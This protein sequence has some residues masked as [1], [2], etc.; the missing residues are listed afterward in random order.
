MLSRAKAK[1]E[2]SHVKFVQADITKPWSFGLEGHYDL[3]T[4]SLV[5]EH[6]AD[7][8][9]IFQ[10][11]ARM[12]KPEGMVYVGE[13]HPFKQY[14]GS[15]AR[16]ETDQGLTVVECYT[17]HLSDFVQSASLSGLKLIDLREYFDEGSEKEVPRIVTLLFKKMADHV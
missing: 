13:L 3:V 9:F 1:V 10:Q 6:I 5:L 12:L 4:F 11:T 7:L 15:K 17:H 14:T 16:F 8:N 2:A